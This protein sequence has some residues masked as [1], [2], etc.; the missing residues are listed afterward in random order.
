MNKSDYKVLIVLVRL[1]AS[2]DVPYVDLEKLVVEFIRE[3]RDK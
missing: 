3:H 1:F 2:L